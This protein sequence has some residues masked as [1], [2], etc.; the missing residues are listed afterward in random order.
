[1]QSHLYKALV[2][3]ISAYFS[4]FTHNIAAARSNLKS[5]RN[6]INSHNFLKESVKAEDNLAKDSSLS[7]SKK[8]IVTK[9]E[10]IQE[11]TTTQN[12]P[13]FFTIN[14][15]NHDILRTVKV[16]VLLNI[17]AD[18]CTTYNAMAASFKTVAGEL[19][20]KIVCAEIEVDSFEDSDETIQFL[21]TNYNVSINCIP[22]ILVLKDNKV[23]EQIEGTYDKELFKTKIL[24]HL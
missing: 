6:R 24:A 11:K 16:P 4:F 2:L 7:S 9:K 8:S 22:T 20:K 23:Q 13:L 18:W 12:F 17:K 19:Q 3:V 21:K 15:K 14:P 1:M 5:K 10:P